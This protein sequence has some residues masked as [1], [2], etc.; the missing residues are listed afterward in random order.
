MSNQ[1]RL[2]GDTPA[3]ASA[4]RERAIALGIPPGALNVSV[5]GQARFLTLLTDQVRPMRGGIRIVHAN[6]V[7]PDSVEL[8]VCTMGFLDSRGGNPGYFTNS[9][10]GHRAPGQRMFGLD[11][12]SWIQA[13]APNYYRDV[14]NVVSHEAIDPDAFTCTMNG[15]QTLCRESDASWHQ[16]NSGANVAMSMIAR[17]S[18]GLQIDAGTQWNYAANYWNYPALAGTILQKVGQ[19]SGTTSGQVTTNCQ[20]MQVFD[21]TR[22]VWL[23][24]QGEVAAGAGA[25][26]SG[27][28]VFEVYSGYNVDVAGLLWGGL[29]CDAYVQNCTSFLYSNFQS[30]IQEF[31]AW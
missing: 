26:D 3:S 9:H 12:L 25:G 17:T 11:T 31:G 24:C 7:R 21:G 5:S 10:C 28:P 16:F 2:S 15:S 4:I 19:E 22:E 30:I 6:F 20:D 29:N 23:L 18:S 14:S 1:L 27:S 13:Y 8:Y